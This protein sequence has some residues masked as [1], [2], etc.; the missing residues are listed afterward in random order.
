MQILNPESDTVTGPHDY[1]STGPSA[2]AKDRT[3]AEVFCPYSQRQGVITDRESSPPVAWWGD[4]PDSEPTDRDELLHLLAIGQLQVVDDENRLCSPRW[5][6]RN[7]SEVHESTT[8]RTSQPSTERPGLSG[9]SD[10]QYMGSSKALSDGG[11]GLLSPKSKTSTRDESEQTEV[12]C[13]QTDWTPLNVTSVSSTR[14]R[15]EDGREYVVDRAAVRPS[16]APST[17]SLVL[18]AE[19]GRGALKRIN[20]FLTHPEVDYQYEPITN[21]YKIALTARYGDTDVATIV[22]GRP[23]SKEADTGDTLSVIRLAAHPARPKNTSSFLLGKAC[24][25]TSLMGYNRL[26]SHAGIA[27]NTG[28]SYQAANFKFTG[29]SRGYS[30]G[31]V[32]RNNHEDYH[33]RGYSAAVHPD[34]T[35]TCRRRAVDPTALPITARTSQYH[36]N[37][38]N[39]TLTREG[40]QEKRGRVH[41]D[42]A[43]TEYIEQYGARQSSEQTVPYAVFGARFDGELAAALILEG[44]RQAPRDYFGALEVT[45][46]ATSGETQPW[47]LGRWLVANAAEWASLWGH[48]EIIVDRE[49]AGHTHLSESVA[50]MDFY[51]DRDRN[52]YAVDPRVHLG[53]RRLNLQQN[54]HAPGIQATLDSW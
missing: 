17:D 28:T 46:F 12:S 19:R 52:V 2:V 44:R 34:E 6:P 50:G 48:D 33:L 42:E 5:T 31:R 45:G 22:L 10:G 47:N 26:V 40:S 49:L 35:A 14:E 25:L 16:G 7:R 3:G 51:P 21:G 39:Y 24:R 13:P 54:P 9:S 53:H 30:D 1:P 18:Y 20:G 32:G 15:L 11:S 36:Q 41:V 43:L 23:P 29:T 4:P 37:A 8:N 27:G 38:Y